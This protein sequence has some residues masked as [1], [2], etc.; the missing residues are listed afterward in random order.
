MKKINW[1]KIWQFIKSRV[2]TIMIIIVLILFSVMQCSQINELKRQRTIH[3]QNDIA[4]KDSL[5][6]EKK[7]NGE[8]EVSIAGYLASVK[9]LKTINEDLW[10]RINTHQGE[11][12]SLNRVIVQ[13][14]QD[15]TQLTKFLNA[16][17]KKIEELLKIDDKTYVAGWTLP[18]K[19]DSTNFDVFSGRTY[20]GITNKDP[21][22][23]SHLDTELINRLSQI[24]L[25]WGQ[26]VIKGQLR[27]FVTSAYPGFTVKSMEGV[28][29]DPNTNPY[30]RNLMKKKHWFTGFGVG[31][32][33][34]MGYNVATNQM[35][36][37][38]GVGLH[39]NIY[40]W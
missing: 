13:L 6:F 32:E 23:L 15:S 38:L 36:L 17:D 9:D 26:E 18:F 29:I 31:P 34:T 4:M 11:V 19:Y 16:K 12:L 5:R 30:I 39:Y 40:Q 27:V 24:D 21:F 10:K 37:V 3:D 33:V 14:R 28:L 35:G 8:L 1:L 2:F 20:I 25:T 22:E 7:K